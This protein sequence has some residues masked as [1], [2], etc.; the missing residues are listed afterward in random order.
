MK[1][2]IAGIGIVFLYI[3][4]IDSSPGLSQEIFPIDG[5]GNH[6]AD[7]KVKIF[8]GLADYQVHTEPRPRITL[9]TE[10]S[11]FMLIRELKDFDLS[12]FPILVFEWM[13][14]KHPRAGDLRKKETDDLA[15]GVYVTLPSFPERVNFKTIGYVWDSQAPVGIYPSHWSKNIK[16]VVLRSGTDGLGRWHLESR[17]V[18]E[19]LKNLWGITVS[20]RRKVVVCLAA[21]SDNTRSASQASLGS[22]YF[23]KP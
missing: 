16:Y 2:A 23:M 1:N 18:P 4:F 21:N 13:V 22:M 17:N 15:A 9:S 20:Q 12:R 19:D 14:E 6:F 10:K 8:R 7:W 11:N 5:F 3:S